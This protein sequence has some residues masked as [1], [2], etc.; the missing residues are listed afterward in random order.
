MLKNKYIRK[1]YSIS[2]GAWRVEIYIFLNYFFSLAI[3]TYCIHQ[4]SKGLSRK[5]FGSHF[6]YQSLLINLIDDHLNQ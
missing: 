4:I 1:P 5:L 2:T 3:E 6:Y